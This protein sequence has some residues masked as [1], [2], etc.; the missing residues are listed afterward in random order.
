MFCVAKLCFSAC[1][2]KQMQAAIFREIDK[3][4]NCIDKR[5]LGMFRRWA[6]WD[7]GI[8]PARRL[9][10]YLNICLF[11]FRKFLRW[12]VER[13]TPCL[14]AYSDERSEED[15]AVGDGRIKSVRR[16]YRTLKRIGCV[17]KRTCNVQYAPRTGHLVDS[18]PR[19]PLAMLVRIRCYA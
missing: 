12:C 11:K 9:G 5:G 6:A 18:L 14:T 8:S 15:C 7:A 2:K 19:I 1:N 17:A 16:A 3:R 4:R 10:C 13:T